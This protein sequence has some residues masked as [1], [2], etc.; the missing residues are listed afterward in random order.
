MTETNGRL[1]QNKK[2]V[3]LTVIV[4]FL[5]IVPSLYGYMA[6]ER[7]PQGACGVEITCES[8]VQV[9]CMLWFMSGFMAIV[10]IILHEDEE[11]E[12]RKARERDEDDH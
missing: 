3:A 1:K 8:P 7:V 9:F 5:F 6:F 10:M 11:E 4:L 12:S 2:K